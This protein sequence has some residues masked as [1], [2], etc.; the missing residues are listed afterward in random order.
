MLKL[1]IADDE[2]WVRTTIRSLIPFEKLD[3]T[4]SCE[5]SNGI[6]ALELCRQHE[7]DILLTDIMMPGLTGLE[8]MKEVRSLLPDLKI[9]VISGYN[10]FEYAK[11][12]VK[13]GIIDYLLKP[14]DEKE[15]T[16]VLVRIGSELSQKA[17][18][19]K[20]SEAEKEQYRQA[21]PVM[22]ETFLNQVISQNSMTSERIRGELQKY[23]INFT[24][25]S[26]TLCIIKPDESLKTDDRRM[27]A[28]YYRSLVKWAMKRYAKAVT[29]PLEHDRTVIVSLINS[30]KEIEGIK[31]AFGLINRVMKRK[32]SMSVSAGVSGSTH[33]FGMLCSLFTDATE[34]SDTRFWEGP[35]TISFYKKGCL[36]E[37]MRLTLPEETLNKITLNL[38]LSN[39][40][41]AMSYIESVCEALKKGNPSGNG[42][43]IS[44]SLVKEF[45]WQF[46]QSIIIIL[47]IQ[48]PFVRNEAV[49]TGEQPYDRLRDTS[50]ID[51]LES[52]AKDLLTHVYNFF[53]DKN[54]LDNIGLVANAKKIIENN[55]AGDIS[56]EQVA[57]HV[58]LSPAYLSEL[59]KKETGMSFIDYKTIIRIDQAKK[60]LSAPSMNIAEVSAKVGYSDPKYFSKLFKKITGKTI[61]EYKKEVRGPNY[62]QLEDSQ[63]LMY[64]EQEGK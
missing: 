64:E 19:Q 41:T 42:T 40:Q 59:F 10:D 38:K 13:Y 62:S 43:Y 31:T 5:A 11:T 29:F 60:L 9:V 14:V 6:E 23:G 12:A 52:V 54:P 53:H 7:P 58:H 35:G 16:E 24:N 37:E 4:L 21:L 45:F 44:P 2:K 61:F 36:S 25:N 51:D 18:L 50:F 49:M 47:N 22:C 28:D 8:L 1:I 26:F 27:A 48:L 39:I 3:L 57:K 63:D 56:L 55:Y 34:A 17:Q 32:Y 33:Q 46:I 30:D 15:L 20:K